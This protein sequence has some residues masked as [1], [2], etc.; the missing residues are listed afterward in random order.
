MFFTKEMF[1]I[2]ARPRLIGA[3]LAALGLGFAFVLAA[4]LQ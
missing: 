4:G 3:A 1:W 2:A